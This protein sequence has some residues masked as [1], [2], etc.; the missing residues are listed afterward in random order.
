MAK[1]EDELLLALP[2][3]NY[4]KPG[5]CTGNALQQN[6]AVNEEEAIADNPFS[7]L[8]QLKK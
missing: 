1:R 5:D 3:V 4:H 2:I 7:V 8:Q 6:E